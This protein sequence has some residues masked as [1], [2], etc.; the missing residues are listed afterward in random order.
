MTSALPINKNVARLSAPPV[1]VVQD[2]ISSYNDARGELIDLSQAV[3]GYPPHPDMVAA[4]GAAA[5]HPDS[6]NYG[7]IEGE[8][9]LRAAYAV[10]LSGFYP[11][12]VDPWRE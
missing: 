3:P 2:W 7:F 6:H 12:V 11:D 4:L 1:A 8:P 9:T 5:S 10:H